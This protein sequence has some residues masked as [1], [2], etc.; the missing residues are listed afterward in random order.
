MFLSEKF[1]FNNTNFADINIY[2]C[3]RDSDVIREIG[4]GYDVGLDKQEGF[5]NNPMYLEDDN[6]SY[7]IEL[8]LLLYDMKNRVKLTWTNEIIKQV[9][10]LL[11][12][13]SFKEFYTEDNNDVV[14]FLKV[15]N[16]QKFFTQDRKGYLKVTFKS[17]DKYC[18]VKQEFTKTI[19]GTGSL[20]INNI[21]NNIYKP[22]IEIINQGDSTT[23]NK[24][25][26]LEITGI[27]NGR[28]VTIDNL[29]YTV[30][31]DNENIFSC[32]NR[33]W[34]TLNKGNNT[35]ILKGNMSVKI[36]CLFPIIM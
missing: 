10:D 32:C 18:Y 29:I 21:S 34:V 36:S 8:N 25:N 7:E 33:K 4:F 3:D 26:N 11:I 19:N 5:K 31:S 35:L 1:N 9:Y 22:I 24:I 2:L 20:E 23:I 13:D 30:L 12:T 15:T 28:K 17:L 14:Y 27:A 16:I 6:G